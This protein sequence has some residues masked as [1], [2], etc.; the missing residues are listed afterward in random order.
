MAEVTVLLPGFCTPR[1]VMHMCL[2]AAF[3][4]AA[5]QR[6]SAYAASITT[7]TPRGLM[8]SSTA[9]AICRVRRS[10]TWSRRA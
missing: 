3:S 7:A 2:R 6:G 10:W 9:A 8:A 4:L 1:I 5:M